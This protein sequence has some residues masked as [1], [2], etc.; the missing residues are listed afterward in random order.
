VRR[1]RLWFAILALAGLVATVSAFQDSSTEVT[2]RLRFPEGIDLTGLQIQY[3]LTG[4]FGGY[5]APA[6]LAAGR[7]ESVIHASHRGQLATTFQAVVGVPGYRYVLLPKSPI[8]SQGLTRSIELEPLNRIPLSGELI[9]A[10]P[11]KGLTIE[12]GYLTDWECDFFGLIDCLQAPHVVSR[13]RIAEDGSF[14]LQIPDFAHDPGLPS[15]PRLGR[16]Q[17]IIRDQ[18]TL[19]P[20]Y[21]LEEVQTRGRRAEVPVASQYPQDLQLVVVPRR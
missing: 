17:L 9:L 14:T 7:R 10:R 6:Q 8:E 13:A 5:G 16:L 11:V 1:R 2:V 19:N 21:E 3:F 20:I 12:A 15:F 4:P 18:I